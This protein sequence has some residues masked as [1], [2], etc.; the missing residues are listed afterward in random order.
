[1][2]YRYPIR[3]RGGNR[4]IAIRLLKIDESDQTIRESFGLFLFL[5]TL[6]VLQ[7]VARVGYDTG[8]EL[9]TVRDRLSQLKQS[10]VLDIY[11]VCDCCCQLDSAIALVLRSG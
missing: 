6:V 4:S 8:K 11:I 10:G 3:S 1:M 9:K 2:V 7:Y 5:K